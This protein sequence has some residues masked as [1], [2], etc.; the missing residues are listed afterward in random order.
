[1]QETTSLKALIDQNTEL[2]RV[3]RELAERI[4]G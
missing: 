3:T 2:T 4:E 1:V